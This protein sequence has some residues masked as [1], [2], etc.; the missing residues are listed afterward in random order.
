MRGVLALACASLKHVSCNNPALKPVISCISN[1][2]LMGIIL[3]SFQEGRDGKVLWRR[4]VA[5]E[6]TAEEAGSRQEAHAGEFS[7]P[8]LFPTC[9]YSLHEQGGPGGA[10]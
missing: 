4:R 6:E 9:T 5:E 10:S 3:C 8:W 2:P 7:I 1:P